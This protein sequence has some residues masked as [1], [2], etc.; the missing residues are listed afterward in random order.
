MTVGRF[1]SP[2]LKT[3]NDAITIDAIPI[4]LAEYA[5]LKHTITALATSIDLTL[6]PFEL[7]CCTAFQYFYQSGVHVCVVEC[8]MGGRQDATNV[9]RR[10]VAC[11]FTSVGLDHQV[12]L[13]DS[14]QAIAQEKAGIIKRY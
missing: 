4:P 10:P 12:W 1:T 13:G 9:V 11:V 8:G 14:V 7:A 3:A 5:R 2:F 6:S